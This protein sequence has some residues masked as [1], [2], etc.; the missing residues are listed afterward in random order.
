MDMRGSSIAG[1]RLRCEYLEGRDCPS[2]QIF[3]FGGFLVVTGDA[4]S[5]TIVVND[6]GNGRLAI[7]ADGKSSLRTNVQTVV[8]ATGGGDDT[9]SY[10]LFGT[11]S[12]ANVLAITTGAGNDSISL[13]GSTLSDSLTAG[14]NAGIGDDDISV[15]LAGVPLGAAVNIFLTGGAGNDSFN[16]NA[17]GEVDGTLNVRANGGGGSDTLSGDIEV[18]AGSTGTVAAILAGSFG[19]DFLDLSV[20]GAGLGGI[21]LTAEIRGGLGTDTGVATSNVTQ[22]SIEA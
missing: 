2:A 3:Q 22:V 19:D 20:T 6:L 7:V 17:S 8:V 9:V 14:I 21:G 16:V 15:N 10:N 12:A 5:N 18:A 13:N 1:T 11:A 4:N